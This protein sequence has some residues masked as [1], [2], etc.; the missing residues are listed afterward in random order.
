MIRHDKDMKI[1]GQTIRA[2][3]KRKQ[4]DLGEKGKS[5]ICSLVK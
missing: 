4:D 2:V 1:E 3:S 5:L